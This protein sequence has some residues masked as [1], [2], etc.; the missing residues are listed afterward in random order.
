MTTLASATLDLA[1]LITNVIESTATGGSATTLLDTSITE[2][3]DHFNGGTIWVLSG[4]NA[5]K[6]R[7]ITDWAKT[8]GTYTFATMTSSNAAGNLYAACVSDYPRSALIQSINKALRSIGGIPTLYTHSTFVTVAG[9]EAYTLPEGVT[10]VVKVEIAMMTTAPYHYVPHYGWRQ[11]GT[12][13][14]FDTERAWGESD[15]LIRLTHIAEPAWLDEDT[16]EISDYVH[17]D[18]LTWKAAVHA[19]RWRVQLY[20]EDRPDLVKQL[21]EALAQEAKMDN[22]YPIPE[23]HRDA[24]LGGGYEMPV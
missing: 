5:G 9:Q 24:H 3:D 13:L 17:I 7:T 22:L 6:S 4:N 12:Q 18:R 14:L 8:T 15:Y 10:K 2:E 20:Q 23:I 11:I 21:N 19:L 16:D 1:R